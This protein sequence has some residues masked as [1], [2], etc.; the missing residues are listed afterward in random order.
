MITVAE[1]A[2]HHEGNFDNLLSLIL[3][4][5]K[6]N[7]EYVKFQ[8]HIDYDYLVSEKHSKYE[9][10][11]SL[12]FTYNQWSEALILSNEIGLKVIVMP[13]CL[14]AIELALNHE[15][16]F[17]EL[18]SIQWNDLVL[19]SKMEKSGIPIIVSVGGRTLNEIEQMTEFFLKNLKILVVGLQSFPTQVNNSQLGMIDFLKT[20]YPKLK[21]GYADH[22]NSISQ[23]MA[24]CSLASNLGV[25]YLEKHISIKNLESKIDIASL[26]Y[27]EDFFALAELISYTK[28]EEF[29]DINGYDDSTAFLNYRNRQCK[30]V[31]KKN[32]SKGDLFSQENLC[33][34]L[35]D[36]DH[37]N[38][39][40]N[41]NELQGQKAAKNYKRGEAV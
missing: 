14:T 41:I 21:I 32:I 9:D 33:L 25:S 39:K 34:K 36:T 18:H 22:S 4:S 30:L 29:S 23:A 7:V 28:S 38:T 26:F 24:L 37:K 20:K 12:Q 16:S 19:K 3:E 5:K 2:F 6:A 13:L 40:S 10:L 35:I 27:K 31:A 15:V 11:K 1:T 8:V 17:L